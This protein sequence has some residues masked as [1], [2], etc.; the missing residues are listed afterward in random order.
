MTKLLTTWD[1]IH[2]SGFFPYTRDAY[3]EKF[4]LRQLRLRAYRAKG[5][6][7]LVFEQ[8]GVNLT[9]LEREAQNWIAV[10]DA[11]TKARPRWLWIH[12]GPPARATGKHWVH[13]PLR[14]KQL[15]IPASFELVVD[16]ASK[17]LADAVCDVA[18]SQLPYWRALASKLTGETD[19]A[20]APSPLE[21]DLRNA[22]KVRGRKP[23]G[24]KELTAI[25]ELRIATT[26]KDFV[27]NDRTDVTDL[28]ALTRLTRLEALEA[29]TPNVTDLSPLAGL[30][31][32]RRLTFS[33]RRP[34]M[35]DDLSP[36]A[37]LDALEEVKL[38]NI[39][40][41]DLRPLSRKPNLTRL[42]VTAPV[43]RLPALLPSLMYLSLNSERVQDAQALRSMKRLRW[44]DLQGGALESLDFA[45]GLHDL[46]SLT[47]WS[48]KIRDLSALRELPALSD[49]NIVAPVKDLS[50]LLTLPRL[51]ALDLPKAKK[52]DRVARELNERGV[53]VTFGISE[54][55]SGRLKRLKN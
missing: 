42:S 3:A 48:P 8:I 11:K 26:V 13:D 17:A 9:V 19:S 32:L 35:L 54:A 29:Y 55:M 33:S 40:A 24:Q 51:S 5:D 21:S 44:V 46:E 18:P 34:S 31:K 14:M 6:W 16:D 22:A 28:A 4:K 1:R 49:V 12:L 52:N 23:L 37:K 2:R 43:E 53:N 50:P 38:Y 39:A 25:K 20:A 10:L 30:T 41:T 45:K 27:S 7:L 36:L 47:C 15:A